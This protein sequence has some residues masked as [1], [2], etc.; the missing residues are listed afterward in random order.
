MHK[1]LLTFAVATAL[2]VGA[3]FAETGNTGE[4]PKQG[5]RSVMEIYQ[6]RDWNRL[7]RERCADAPYVTS[8]DTLRQLR[9][10]LNDR[11]GDEQALDAFVQKLQLALL[12]KPNLTSDGRV[13]IF[14]VNGET[15]S[16]AK[17]DT[18]QWGVRL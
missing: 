6:S 11:Y 8:G 3:I 9:Q 18:G 4:S 12:A 7:L 14:S 16:L 13:A 17:M 10:E 5:L 2:F 15:L 1:T